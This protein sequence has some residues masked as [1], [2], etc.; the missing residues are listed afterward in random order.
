MFRKIVMLLLLISIVLIFCVSCDSKP[1][2][3]EDYVNLGDKNLEKKKIEEALVAY[4][5]AF[6][7]NPDN[8]KAQDMF[9][10]ISFQEMKAYREEKKHNE[11]LKIARDVVKI[12]P[13]YDLAHTT[14]A[15]AYMDVGEFDSAISEIYLA[16][17]INPTEADFYKTLG[18][19]Y[20]KAGKM[21]EAIKAYDKSK[22]L[23]MKK[24]E[25]IEKDLLNPKQNNK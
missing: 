1:K 4:R 20:E 8:I 2:T 13:K 7:I 22:E 25:S 24:A 23:L 5:K 14:L 12:M 21:E 17:E 11:V 18:Y 16:I 15:A 19:A 3:A 10:F 6:E 9:F